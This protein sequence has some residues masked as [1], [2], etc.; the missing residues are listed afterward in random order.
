MI[1]SFHE[2][3]LSSTY[4][5]RRRHHHHQRRRRHNLNHTRKNYCNDDYHHHHHHHHHR[6]IKFLH[7]LPHS[8]VALYN[9]GYNFFIFRDFLNS[10]RCPTDRVPVLAG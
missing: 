6:C 3:L 9:S 7:I 1:F 5:C 2:V 8:H 10:V 4:D